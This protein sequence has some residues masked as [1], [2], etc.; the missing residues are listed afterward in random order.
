MNPLYNFAIFSYKYAVRLASLRNSKAKKMLQGHKQVFSTLRNNIKKGDDYIWLHASSLGEF[1][2]GRPIIERIKEIK[3]EQKILLT[4]FSPS[5]YEVRKNYPMVDV[6][7]Y[8]PFDLPG[9]V[10]RF[11]DIVNPRMAIFVKYEFWG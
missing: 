10:E 2:Q 4:F 5:G 6:V 11:L 9:N 3:P 7:C 8:L 1:E